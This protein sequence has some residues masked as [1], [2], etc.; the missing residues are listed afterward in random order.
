MF[1]DYQIQVFVSYLGFPFLIA[2]GQSA[3]FYQK[4]TIRRGLMFV[5]SVGHPWMA[6]LGFV[7]AF[8]FCDS[9]AP[10]MNEY[11]I[12]VFET[13]IGLGLAGAVVS[14]F[15]FR[16]RWWLIAIHFFTALVA[17][18]TLLIG[19]MALSHDWI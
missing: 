11:K 1:S 3:V 6:P 17:D 16:G 12:A 5:V 19:G 13:L 14:T 7:F 15:P 10:W 9:T 18:W 8:L 4:A 2:Y